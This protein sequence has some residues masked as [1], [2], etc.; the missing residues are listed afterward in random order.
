MSKIFQFL[1]KKLGN[2]SLLK[3]FD[4]SIENTCVDMRNLHVFGDECSHSFW[5]E[6]FDESGDLQEHELRGKSD[7]PALI[8]YHTEKI[9]IGAF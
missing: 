2:S 4:G 8:Q 3:F 5:A 9:D 1:Q 6:L 7:L